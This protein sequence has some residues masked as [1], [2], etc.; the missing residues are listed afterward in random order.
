MRSPILK[1]YYVPVE[2]G[3]ILALPFLLLLYDQC[4][5]TTCHI[6]IL[7]RNSWCRNLRSCM[8]CQ[9]ITV[10]WSL[11]SSQLLIGTTWPHCR[12]PKLWTRNYVVVNDL[13][14]V[15]PIP[16]PLPQCHEI[17]VPKRAV[18]E[19]SLDDIYNLSLPSCLGHVASFVQNLMSC[20]FRRNA[21]ESATQFCVTLFQ[22]PTS[23]GWLP[24][25]KRHSRQ[26]Y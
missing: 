11:F 7:W 23:V 4:G 5:L 25:T 12:T 10:T 17:F 13:Q 16:P 9:W 19:N 20:S 22:V 24:R 8:S 26:D 2:C 14:P 15:R 21:Y 18:I 1:L 3:I 6:T